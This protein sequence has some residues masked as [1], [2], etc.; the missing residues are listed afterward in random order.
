MLK[1][2]VPILL[3][4]SFGV[5]APA[6]APT[7]P[8]QTSGMINGRFWSTLTE[9]GK[10]GWVLGYEE[11]ITAATAN[12]ASDTACATRANGLYASYGSHLSLGEMVRGI[13]HFYQDTPENA[14]V[15]VA[16]A[17]HYVILKASGASQST[18]DIAASAL[19]KASGTLDKKP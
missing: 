1:S 7:A 16:S 8:D 10:L 11:G 5:A 6:Q 17:L 15:A 4:I 3:A 9:G 18:L 12:A 14:P 19:R 2:I 13:D